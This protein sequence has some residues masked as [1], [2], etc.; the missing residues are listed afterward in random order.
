MTVGN[1]FSYWGMSDIKSTCA[2]LAIDSYN[3]MEK[4]YL[5]NVTNGQL[6]DGLDEFYKDYRNRTIRINGAVWLVLQG[7]AGTPKEKIEMMTESWR[8]NSHDH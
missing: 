3:K 4:Q 7:I 5:A 2:S 8:K 1:N 6:V